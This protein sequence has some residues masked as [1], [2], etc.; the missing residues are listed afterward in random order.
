M[1]L[2]NLSTVVN[3]PAH[4]NSREISIDR[5]AADLAV[6]IQIASVFLFKVFHKN[7]CTLIKPNNSIVQS[8][9]SIPVNY[10]YCF[11]LVSDCETLNTF[12]S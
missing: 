8:F 7:G 11:S 1:S 3:Q 9:S 6:D 2:L 10:N 5:E 12:R 4:F